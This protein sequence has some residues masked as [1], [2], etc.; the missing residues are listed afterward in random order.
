MAVGVII[1][2]IVVGILALGSLFWVINNQ[3]KNDD[4]DVL[5]EERFVDWETDMLNRDYG[6]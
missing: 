4:F 5:A 6:E 2:G 3:S 1:T